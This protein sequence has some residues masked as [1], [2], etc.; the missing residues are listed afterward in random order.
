M[1]KDNPTLVTEFTVM[2]DANVQ[3][4]LTFEDSDL[5]KEGL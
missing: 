3:G 1:G 2:L 4:L 5:D